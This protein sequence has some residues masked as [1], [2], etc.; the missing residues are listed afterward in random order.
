MLRVLQIGVPLSIY[1][2][3]LINF[4]RSNIDYQKNTKENIAFR[5]KL[6]VPTEVLMSIVLYYIT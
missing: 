5:V 3:S 6:L 4:K 1:K 2:Y